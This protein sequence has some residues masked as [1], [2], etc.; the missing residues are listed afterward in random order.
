M[1]SGMAYAS[2]VDLSGAAEYDMRKI[3]NRDE[4]I[5]ITSVSNIKKHNSRDSI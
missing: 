5:N 4:Q 2:K 1:K 3:R